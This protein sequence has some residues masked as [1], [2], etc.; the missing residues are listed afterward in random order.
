M[1]LPGR[2]KTFA[3]ENCHDLL[4]KLEREIDRFAAHCDAEARIDLAFNIGGY[5]M[6]SVRLVFAE[7]IRPEVSPENGSTFR[8]EK[9]RPS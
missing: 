6:A 3:L 4:L 8:F 5:R 9:Y 1:A 7:P 2:E